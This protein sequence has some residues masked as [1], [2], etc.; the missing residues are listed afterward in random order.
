M[1]TSNLVKSFVQYFR[2]FVSLYILKTINNEFDFT[3]HF[4]FHFAQCVGYQKEGSAAIQMSTSLLCCHHTSE[5][6]YL[7]WQML[8]Y[9]SEG[10]PT[11]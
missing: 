9:V 5:W 8:T 1:K 7:S 4:S 2:L 3:Y 10:V 6:H 11:H